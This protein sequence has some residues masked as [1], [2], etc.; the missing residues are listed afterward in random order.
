[1]NKFDAEK[2]CNPLEA[3]NRFKDSKRHHLFAG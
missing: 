1:M 3:K 2:A